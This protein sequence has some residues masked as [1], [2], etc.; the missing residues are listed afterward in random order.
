MLSRSLNVHDYVKGLYFHFKWIFVFFEVEKVY[1]QLIGG[2]RLTP[3][4]VCAVMEWTTIYRQRLKVQLRNSL[5]IKLQIFVFIIFSSSC[6]GNSWAGY[7]WPFSEE[8]MWKYTSMNVS[9]LLISVICH[10]PAPMDIIDK[11]RVDIPKN[12]RSNSH[13]KFKC[14]HPIQYV[15]NIVWY[16]YFSS[17]IL[18]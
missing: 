18:M 13:C 3:T 15:H 11:V 8:N 12:I 4:S 9:S 16:S 2:F 7:G 14:Y 10:L 1:C 17:I 6:H 5:Q